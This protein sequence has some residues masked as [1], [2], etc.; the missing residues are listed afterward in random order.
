MKKK[1]TRCPRCG[2]DVVFYKSR[3]HRC[4]RCNL[5][6]TSTFSFKRGVNTR[7]NDNIWFKFLPTQSNGRYGG[8][9]WQGCARVPSDRKYGLVV[10]VPVT[11]EE[12]KKDLA[13][14]NTKLGSRPRRKLPRTLD[15]DCIGS[16]MFK[17]TKD[18]V[19][20]GWDVVKQVEKPRIDFERIIKDY[21][22]PYY[23]SGRY[24]VVNHPVLTRQDVFFDDV[25]N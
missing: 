6:F 11:T 22:Y 21:I 5:L 2:F 24:K 4:R 15:L 16:L 3:K 10:Y 25:I 23:G 8:R 14:I 1:L 9:L 7:Y 13:A 12:Q 20:G 18:K 17:T 19:R